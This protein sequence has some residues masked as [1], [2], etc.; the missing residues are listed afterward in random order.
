[1]FHSQ[2][3]RACSSVTLLFLVS[4]KRTAALSLVSQLHL[5]RTCLPR[6]LWLSLANQHSLNIGLVSAPLIFTRKSLHLSRTCLDASALLTFTHKLLHCCLHPIRE[7]LPLWDRLL[8]CRSHPALTSLILPSGAT[9][10][11]AQVTHCGLGFAR[12]TESAQVLPTVL[13]DWVAL[14]SF[15]SY[16]WR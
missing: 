3:W 4:T 16:L 13:R 12:S 6:Q 10:P 14:Y 2:T 5:S 11:A 1:M 9:H 8:L 15:L 7:G